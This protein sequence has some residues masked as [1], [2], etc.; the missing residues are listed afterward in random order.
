M[1]NVISFFLQIMPFVHSQLFLKV[2]IT[3]ICILFFV[4]TVFGIIAFVSQVS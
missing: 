1:L 4:D 2:L 3:A